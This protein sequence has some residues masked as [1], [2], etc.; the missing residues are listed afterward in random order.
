M[1]ENDMTTYFSKSNDILKNN[2]DRFKSG[3][4]NVVNAVVPPYSN[5]LE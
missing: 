2:E 1:Y 4:G 3:K 5:P